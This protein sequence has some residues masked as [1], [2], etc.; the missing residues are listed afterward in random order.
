[1]CVCVHVHT[2]MYYT[3]TVHRPRVNCT[4]QQEVHKAPSRNTPNHAH[5]NTG[6][7]MYSVVLRQ[8]LLKQIYC[9]KVTGTL[10]KL[11]LACLVFQ[12]A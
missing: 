3:S 1:M 10:E 6:S 11:V 4:E 2:F 5:T 7:Q 12:G 8:D 9:Y